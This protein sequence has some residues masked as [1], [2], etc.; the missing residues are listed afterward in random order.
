MAIKVSTG[1]ANRIADRAAY[2]SVV[3]NGRVQIYSGIQPTNAD[4]ASSGTLLC[5]V[6]NASGAFTAETLPVWTL[7][8]SGASG[9]LD[10]VKI[11]GIELLPAAVSFTTDLSTTAA[12]VAA[13]IT[14]AFTLV[15]YTATS[16]AAVV[17]ITG[18]VGS[19]ANLNSATCV[20]TATTLGATVSSAGA[21]TTSGVNAVNGVTFTYPATGGLFGRSGTWSGLGVAS[22]TAGWFRFL[23][24]GA[25][26]GTSASTTFARIDGSITVTGG[27]GDAT[28]DNTGVTA[29]QVVSVTSFNMGISRG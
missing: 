15:D 18:P 28:I 4:T 9:S 13:A 2:R 7:T 14:G 27:A 25:D 26:T 23:C 12:L 5:T 1:M 21:P 16:N 24:D 11:G 22:G 19:G 20:A 8:L 3:T 29:G 10:S 6:T 17:Y